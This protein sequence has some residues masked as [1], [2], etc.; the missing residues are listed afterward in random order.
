MWVKLDRYSESCNTSND[1]SN[2]ICVPNKT[3]DLNLSVFNMITGI[4]ES[5][6]LTKYISCECKCR[7]E[8]TKCKSNQCWDNNKCQYV[9]KKHHICEKDYVWNLATFVAVKMENI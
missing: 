9:C 3:E 5:K 8:E 4:N 2:K 6:T 7:F 1:L